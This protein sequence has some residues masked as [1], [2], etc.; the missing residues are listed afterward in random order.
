MAEWPL[1][2]ARILIVD[3]EPANVDLLQFALKRA[4]YRD[5]K[6]T[7]DPM[8]VAG[9]FTEFDPD[10]ILLDLHMPGLDGFEVMAQLSDLVPGD[11]YLPV[12]VLTADVAPETK[13]RALAGGAKDFLVKPFDVDEV[14]LRIRNMLETRQLHLRLS[15]SKTA[16]LASVSHQVRGPLDSVLAGALA[17]ERGGLNDEAREGLIRELATNVRR[18]NRLLSELLELDRSPS[19]LADKQGP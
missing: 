8:R 19:G 18:L 1:S 17:L 13:R 16:L 9:L 5:V 6:S 7:I 3:D 10:V 14:I 11:T 12:L 4:G 2:T 15:E